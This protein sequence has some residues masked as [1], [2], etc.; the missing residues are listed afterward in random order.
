MKSRHSKARGGQLNRLALCIAMAI[1]ALAAAQ[2]SKDSLPAVTVEATGQS[3]TTE[4]TGSYTTGAS[5]TATPLSMS[6]R[7]T[8]QSVTV[9][10]KQRIEDQ[11]L[12]TITDVINNTTGVSVNQYETSRG[13]FTA[14]GF[15]INTLLIDGVPTTWEQPWS[16]GEVF[17]SLATYDRVEV[18]RG[19]TGLTT[20]A[21]DPSAAI[22][23]VRKRASSNVFTGSVEL[24]AGSW[25]QRRALV[26]LSTPLNEA[27]TVRARIVGE[28]DDKDSYIRGL[29]TRNSTL[30]AT[31]EA[32]LGPRTLLTAG[33]SRQKFD[34]KGPMWGGLPVWYSEGIRTNWD[35]SKTSAADW[36]R[37]N[38]DYD[39]YF[40]SLEHRFSNDWKLKLSYNHGER[41]AD[42]YLLYLSG[43]PSVFTGL[44]MS[45]FAASYNVKTKQD[46]FSAA[47]SGTV[48][49]LGRDHELA[50]GYTSSTQK[51]IA[52]SRSAT[53]SFGM[54]S[55]FNNWSGAYP[56]PA[57]GA[58]SYYGKSETRQDALY[59]AARLNL[60]DPLKLIVGA[61]VTNYEK[62]G[63][64]IYSNP[65]RLKFNS[66]VTPYAG[67]VFDMSKELSLYA[68][69]TDIF[70]PQNARDINGTYLDPIK[71]KSFET[72]VKGEFLDGRVNASAAVFHIKQKNLAVATTD[73]LTGLG[74]L[75]ETVY[76]ASDGA[77]SNGFELELT[78]ELAR[79]WN[80]SAG[81]TQYRLKDEDG[82]DVNSIYPRK[83]VRLF[84]TYRLPG[85]WSALTLGGGVSWQG[86]TYTNAV[87]PLGET[88][89]IDQGAY[90]LVN[91]MARYEFTPR[92]SA[93]LNINNATNRK[94]YGMFDAYSQLTYL[95]PRNATLSVK[96][97][98]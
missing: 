6:V 42:S 44:G 48:K 33:L 36:T 45:A 87:N 67:I 72:G 22:N 40:A 23:L 84:T 46:D 16:S 18:V 21:G 3:E 43:A 64:D 74:G 60:A 79:G 56:E 71:G 47:A 83:L 27:K 90:A 91:L 97:K 94:Y 63:D 82:Q 75:P 39:T 9:V 62:T 73:R 4:G 24:E 78:G 50:F 13:Q 37:W 95:A 17:T 86:K 52:N 65:Y 88:Q 29:S 58:L 14:R 28:T 8:P 11:G 25:N 49:L 54:A 68:S 61:R 96:Y 26:D 69:Y 57:W 35:T 19:A 31:V 7:E 81:Y 34:T 53:P 41:K 85:A 80:V 92:L 89:R 30:F 76:R 93:Q 15:D 66:E 10:T 38:T 77:T 5:R 55:D 98:F 51:F 20:G 12:K 59:G 1:P 32:D 70:Q 2:E